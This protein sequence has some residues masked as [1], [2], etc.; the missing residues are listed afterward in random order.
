M[1][2]IFIATALLTLVS[3][4]YA[5]T[6]LNVLELREKILAQG[7]PS[8][9]FDRLTRFMLS[10]R[11][12][13]F[14]VDTYTCKDR[15][16]D[17]VKACHEKDRTPSTQTVSFNDP[18]YVAI[19][20]FTKPSSQKRLFLID[21]TEGEVKNYHVSH[22]VG[23][24]DGD[25]A[26]RFSNIQDSRQTSLGFYVTGG[27]YVGKYGEA[28]RM[29]GLEKSND[30]SYVRDIVMHGAW[31]AESSFM[32]KYNP[33]TKEKFGRLGVSWGC[34]AVSESIAK[35]IIPLLQNGGLIYHYQEKLADQTNTGEQIGLP[36][37][38][39]PPRLP[40]KFKPISPKARPAHLL[41]VTD[42]DASP[43]ESAKPETSEK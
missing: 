25:D 18:R 6:S 27:T 42:K 14:V 43:E 11:N 34:P 24:G 23:T 41:K 28:L 31:Y 5:F 2:L 15:P 37:S 22:G 36:S 17:S 29:Y 38:R 3:Q 19:V 12:R 10:N 40:S 7:V 39:R 33:K 9:A 20:D 8:D 35:K 21:L 4:S 16:E 1:R 32:D 13:D 26:V 30:S